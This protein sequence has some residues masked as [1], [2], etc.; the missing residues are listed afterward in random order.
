MNSNLR[1]YFLNSFDDPGNFYAKMRTFLEHYAQEVT[2]DPA[3]IYQYLQA[4]NMKVLK[5]GIYSFYPH[6]LMWAKNYKLTR[7]MLYANGAYD[8]LPTEITSEIDLILLLGGFDQNGPS[9]FENLT[10]ITFD[11]HVRVAE[12]HGLFDTYVARIVEDNSL[13]GR[14]SRNWPQTIHVLMA[15][16]NVEQI[17]KLVLQWKQKPTRVQ[18]A[19]TRGG[20]LEFQP[21]YEKYDTVAE[22][23]LPSFLQSQTFKSTE[24]NSGLQIFYIVAAVLAGWFLIN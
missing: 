12:I 2:L 7:E 10:M 22:S 9:S 3:Q 15:Q 8:D 19:E 17:T 16:M 4:A 13:G 1:D 20:V 21:V 11:K 5:L 6:N 24:T 18:Y 23:Q 14:W